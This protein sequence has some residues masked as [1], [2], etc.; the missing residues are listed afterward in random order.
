MTPTIQTEI[1]LLQDTK[2]ELEIAIMEKGVLVE[3]TDTF[4][5]YPTRISQISMTPGTYDNL[6]K[7]LIDR[8]ITSITI[9]S[10][11]K[12][13][14]DYCFDRCDYL[15]DVTMPEGITEIG[16]NAFSY[17]TSLTTIE[18]PTTLIDIGEVTFESCTN[19]TSITCYAIYPPTMGAGAFD[20][21][22]NCPIYVPADSVDVYKT[23]WSRYA[24]RIQ[25]IPTYKARLTLTDNSVVTIDDDGSGELINEELYPY[26]STLRELEVFSYVNTIA[27]GAC[28][29]FT[30]L[31]TVTLDN[32]VTTL[33]NY[34]F[35][36]CTSLTSFT[37]PGLTSW[38]DSALRQSAMTYYEMP[39]GITS[40][41]G[42]FA[43]SP[44]LEEV[45]FPEGFLELGMNSFNQCTSL[46]NPVLPETLSI[47]SAHATFYGCTGLESITFLSQYP[48]T[49]IIDYIND[50]FD[51][52]NDCPIYVP[53]DSVDYYKQTNGWSQY[54]SRIQA[55][56]VPS[57]M[58]ITYDN[59]GIIET[60]S[61][62]EDHICDGEEMSY[63]TTIKVCDIYELYEAQ[64]PT[65]DIRTITIGENVEIIEYTFWGCF[66]LESI[67]IEATT[68]P[69]IYD[70]VFVSAETN[71]CPIYVPSD[72]L[73]VYLD[74]PNWGMFYSSRLQAIPE[75]Q[76]VD[77]YPELESVQIFK[78]KENLNDVTSGKYII[79]SSGH[80][81]NASL[82]ETTTGT[83]NGINNYS[84]GNTISFDDYRMGQGVCQV[85]ANT[86]NAAMD[87]DATNHKL[88]WTNTNNNTT[89]YLSQRS[90]TSS[91]FKYSG[92]TTVPTTTIT[93]AQ[94]NS[95]RNLTFKQNYALG[96]GN[97]AFSWYN[98]SNSSA[99]T[100]IFI[101]KLETVSAAPVA[102]FTLSDTSEVK[103]YDYSG[104]NANLTFDSNNSAP[105]QST[106][107]EA[108]IKRNVEEIG[109]GTFGYFQYLE[110]VT[111]PDSVDTIGDY[112]FENC[113]SLTSLTVKATYPP[114][115]GSGVFN[116]T[117]ANLVI[118]V[119]AESVNDYKAASGWSDYASKIQ[120]IS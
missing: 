108:S 87:Y 53:A 20:N 113:S 66:G 58:I 83:G 84:S 6:Y 110:T 62:P 67:T 101:Y 115:L 22:N 73:Q 17:C 86:L 42:T 70:D 117:N 5:M 12:K 9:P 104:N 48:P 72:S 61:I 1:E 75:P 25:A 18:I 111:I 21:T 41:N 109:L 38:G 15:T 44:Y 2:S 91:N 56:P 39:E 118:Y 103:V 78:I 112:A 28:D 35:K 71:D 80:I 89:Y 10:S 55:I 11:V 93:V 27:E 31:T 95:N 94:V 43:E 64:H 106:V 57:K 50:M 3:A 85:N 76:P 88:S 68:P 32:S 107:V 74:D 54:A 34:A 36:G 37:A 82:I 63:P 96:Y 40:T 47:I 59:S 4:A 97:P 46:K 8:S 7:S 116:N 92:T 45:I 77:P 19:L 33:E 52:T 16:R 30:A 100:G 120:A 65:S 24:S 90:T 49:V 60:I 26:Q 99:F 114:T 69:E 29:G 23:V 81:L 51:N 102:T 14:R 98:T 119:P 79:Q 105:Y 13:I